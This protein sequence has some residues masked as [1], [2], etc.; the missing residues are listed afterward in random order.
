MVTYVTCNGVYKFYGEYRLPHNNT[1][2]VLVTL[3]SVNMDLRNT[4]D[5]ECMC[6]Q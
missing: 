4:L 3:V 2:I 1:Y 6:L 5:K